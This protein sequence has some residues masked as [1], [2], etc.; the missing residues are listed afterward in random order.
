MNDLGV[1]IPAS[2][3]VAEATE[4]T[5]E[6]R[7]GYDERALVKEW[8]VA[9]SWKDFK[10]QQEIDASFLCITDPDSEE[11]TSANEAFDYGS[12]SVAR[13]VLNLEAPP[14]GETLVD[15]NVWQEAHRL[16]LDVYK[17]TATFPAEEKFGLVSQMRRAAVSVPANIAE[18]FKRRGIND[19]AHFYNIAHA[20]LEELRYYFI[21]SRDL[22]F[23]TDE[24]SLK[25]KAESIGRM[26]T[27]LTKSIKGA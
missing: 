27:A 22:G 24:E 19:K 14:A 13:V 11:E 10:A 4:Q 6:T 26:L 23:K 9:L 21:L 16:V 1:P 5:T 8:Q 15:L 12:I 25:S 18:G 20:S 7:Y 3:A 17:L 2:R